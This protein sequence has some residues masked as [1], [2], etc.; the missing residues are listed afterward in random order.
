MPGSNVSN[1]VSSDVLTLP[2]LYSLQHCPYAMRARMGLMLAQQPVMLR[3]VVTKNKPPEMLA[4]SPKGTVP[5][6]LL[7]DNTVIDESLDIM[8]WALS[9][10]DPHHLLY[11]DVPSAAEEIKNLIDRNDNE[12]ITRLENYKY[13]K[14]HHDFAQL[15]YRDQCEHFTAHLE[16]RLSQ[17][18]FLVGDRPSIAD[19]AILPF[20]R[21]FARVDRQWYLKSPYP[22]LRRW[23]DAQLQQPVFTKVMAKYP[24]WITSGEEFLI[25]V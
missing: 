25:E 8:F 16:Q 13:S 5:V 23:L 4:V 2:I 6:L 19:Y 18:D 11:V 7:P 24:Q 20:I 17:H 14:R 3:A 1:D 15:H 21:Q 10:Y 9:Q 22:N 12:F